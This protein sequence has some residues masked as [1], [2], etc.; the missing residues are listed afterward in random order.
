MIERGRRYGSN[1]DRQN[2]RKTVALRMGNSRQKELRN[3]RIQK[4]KSASMSTVIRHAPT[5]IHCDGHRRRKKQR[6]CIEWFHL[7][8]CQFN[9]RLIF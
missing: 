2:V 9:W 8:Q 7:R 3:K 5:G 6:C 4:P 1:G